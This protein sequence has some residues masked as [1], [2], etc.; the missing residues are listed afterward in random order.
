[1]AEFAAFL[2]AFCVG[3]VWGA[4]A[5]RRG[6]RRGTATWLSYPVSWITFMA[7]DLLGMML[8]D[9]WSPP[10]RSLLGNVLMGGAFATTISIAAPL[11]CWVLMRIL[12]AET[13]R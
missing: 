1:M 13:E 9:S 2:I 8:S 3:A 11:G 7:I 5:H 12:A 6:N 4:A 10:G